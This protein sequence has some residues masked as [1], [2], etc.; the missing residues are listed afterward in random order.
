MIRGILAGSFLGPIALDLRDRTE[1]LLAAF[2]RSD[3]LG[4]I[5]NDQIASFLVSRMCGGRSV[6]IDVG[7]HIGSILAQV[8]RFSPTT[9]IIAF[10]PIPEKA[11]QLSK[12]FPEVTVHCCAVGQRQGEATFFVDMEHSGYSSLSRRHLRDPERIREI[13]VE[14]RRIDD[15]IDASNVDVIKIDVEGME[16]DVLM[17]AVRLVETCRPVL[18]FES[19]PVPLDE[20]T[21]DK[22]ALWSWLSEREYEILIPNRVAH[23]GPSL[24]KEGFVESHYYPRRTTNYFAVP[25]EGREEIRSKAREILGIG[26]TRFVR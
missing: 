25:T 21:P 23:E 9:K 19:A 17:G 15:L 4:V 3:Q 10:E 5:L 16:L 24:S 7:S 18:M 8:K 1:V 14:V 20:L 26:V 13:S 11:M 12:R 22:E 2:S 6:F